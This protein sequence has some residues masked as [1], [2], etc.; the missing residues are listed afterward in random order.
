M[1]RSLRFFWHL[2]HFVALGESHCRS[3][4]TFRLLSIV[5]VSQC[6]EMILISHAHILSG[7][8]ELIFR[9]NA[10]RTCL[11]VNCMKSCQH[12]VRGPMG[13]DT[14]KDST[15]T[16]FGQAPWPSVAV[17]FDCGEW[18]ALSKP[19]RGKRVNQMPSAPSPSHHH[20][21]WVVS[22]RANT[23]V[24]PHPFHARYIIQLGRSTRVLREYKISHPR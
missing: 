11:S 23:Q 1:A 9:R 16:A 8:S 13:Q 12:H 24:R 14:A 15:I 4:L 18:Q 22:L 2:W 7:I 21:G 3:A 6:F 19:Y 20:F 10:A 5:P 17:V